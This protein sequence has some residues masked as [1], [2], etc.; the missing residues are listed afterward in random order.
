MPDRIEYNESLGAEVQ[1]LVDES[2]ELELMIDE[3]QYA[4]VPP[5]SMPKIRAAMAIKADEWTAWATTGTNLLESI[6]GSRK[7]PMVCAWL[8]WVVERENVVDAVRRGRGVLRG[9]L[10]A[11]RCGTLWNM[12]PKED[13]AE[14]AT[15]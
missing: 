12:T 5:A 1:R 3:E 4:N 9:F 11:W 14:D 6:C 7:H 15:P 8:L 2:R 10:T 13:G